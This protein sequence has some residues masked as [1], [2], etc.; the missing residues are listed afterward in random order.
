MGTAIDGS[1]P[2]GTVTQ[3]TKLRGRGV[4]M[5]AGQKITVEVSTEQSGRREQSPGK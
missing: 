3:V 2:V 4:L 1:G 5:E